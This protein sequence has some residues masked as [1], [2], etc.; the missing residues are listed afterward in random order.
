MRTSLYFCVGAP[1]QV[2]YSNDSTRSGLRDY[3]HARF[4]NK[5]KSSITF[6]LCTKGSKRP[7]NYKLFSPLE[8]SLPDRD[9]QFGPDFCQ[10]PLSMMTE[11]QMSHASDNRIRVK[12]GINATHRIVLVEGFFSTRFP[13][14]VSPYGLNRVVRSVLIHLRNCSNA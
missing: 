6:L 5:Q 3:I 9:L 1:R 11:E 4:H 10:Y 8:T 14:N 2:P 13:Y 7:P 12:D